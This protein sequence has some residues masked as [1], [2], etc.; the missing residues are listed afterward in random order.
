[1]NGE[2]R[3]VNGK[4]YKKN[5]KICKK[6][7]LLLIILSSEDISADFECFELLVSTPLSFS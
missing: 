6:N 4:I 7:H 5:R 1:M 3:N 2:T